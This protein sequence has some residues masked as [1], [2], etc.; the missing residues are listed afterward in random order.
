MDIRRQ[1]VDHR[2]IATSKADNK[3]E[4]IAVRTR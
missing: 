1:F 4:I 2:L 3:L